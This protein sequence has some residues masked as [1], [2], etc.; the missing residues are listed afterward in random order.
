[1]T[2]IRSHFFEL[3][4]EDAVFI[5]TLNVK[6]L[7]DEENLEQ[8]DRELSTVVESSI[9]CRMVCDLGTVAYISSSAIGK[10]ISLHRK[11]MRTNGQLVLCR[12]Q[13]AVREILATSHLLQYFHVMDD[14][15][16]AIAKLK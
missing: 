13:P 16:Q 3:T 14:P 11:M 2:D 5:A 10:F 9:P 4:R 8:F 6:Q 15:Q 1:M 12:L 7:T